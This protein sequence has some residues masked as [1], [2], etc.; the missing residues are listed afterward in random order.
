MAVSKTLL[1]PRGHSR[2]E[3]MDTEGSELWRRRSLCATERTMEPIP[4]TQFEDARGGLGLSTQTAARAHDDPTLAPPTKRG[5]FS[6]V[7][8]SKTGHRD[9]GLVQRE[10]MERRFG[11]TRFLF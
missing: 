5:L 4:Q 11:A 2:Q 8:E 6:E 7:P 10:I 9:S 1:S 3:P